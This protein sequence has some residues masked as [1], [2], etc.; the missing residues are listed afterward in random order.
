MT[1]EIRLNAE[2]ITEHEPKIYVSI[3]KPCHMYSTVEPT[4]C[5]ANK[6]PKINMSKI[7]A[8][9]IT[10]K[11]SSIESPIT[12]SRGE[13]LDNW[14]KRSLLVDGLKKSKNPLGDEPAFNSYGMLKVIKKKLHTAILS[15]VKQ[16]F[17]AYYR[18]RH[19]QC[20]RS[21]SCLWHSLSNAWKYWPATNKIVS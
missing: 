15:K 17:T 14:R 21:G 4:W 5:I 16:K 3:R 19:Q 8:L 13:Y 6:I 12:G 2:N 18:P 11:Q 10:H 9:C 7:Q 1:V 20:N